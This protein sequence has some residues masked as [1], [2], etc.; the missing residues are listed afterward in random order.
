MLTTSTSD[1]E[2]PDSNGAVSGEARLLVTCDRK[3]VFSSLSLKIVPNG[4]IYKNPAGVSEASRIVSPVAIASFRSWLP[5]W[6]ASDKEPSNSSYACNRSEAGDVRAG[7]SHAP[8]PGACV[9]RGK[10]GKNV[11]KSGQN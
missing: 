11:R 8:T 2:N 1:S 5:S 10:R 7:R 6:A 4:T 9:F 3:D